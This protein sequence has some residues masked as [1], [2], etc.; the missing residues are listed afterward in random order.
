MKTLQK[1]HEY[2]AFLK[3]FVSKPMLTGSIVPSS[4]ALADE[5]LRGVDFHSAK[6]VI[7]VGPGT[8]AITRKIMGMI[9]PETTYYGLD[10]NP[11]FVEKLTHLFPYGHFHV[12]S[13][14]NLA[15][16]T[17]AKGLPLSGYVI[18]GLPWSL[19]KPERQ[20]KI[21]E[22]IAQVLGPEGEFRT[23]AYVH[24]HLLR[25][26]RSFFKIL[27]QHFK[28]V[29]AMPVVWANLPPAIVYR[30]RK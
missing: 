13:A 15:E 9:P 4:Q 12:G 18:S 29:Q 26:G 23:F 21:L 28:V 30:C 2:H 10:I 27:P 17:R 19:I 3:E 8:G 6:S 5:L 11:V 14:E 22:N 24:A 20:D 1:F 7:E 25:Y 16:Y